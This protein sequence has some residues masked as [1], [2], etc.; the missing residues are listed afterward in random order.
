MLDVIARFGN[1]G[2]Q[3]LQQIGASGIF[4]FTMLFRKPGIPRL[5]PL[6]RHQL[7]FIGVLSCLII[8]VSGLFIGMVVGLQGY[9]TLQKFGAGSQLGQLLALSIAREL[10]PVISA[11]LFAGRAGSALTAEIGLMKTTEQLSSMD[12]MG[13]D[14]LGR[15]IYPRFIAG[16]ISL[17]VLALIFSAVAIYGGYFVGVHWLGVDAGS[18]WSNMQAAVNFRIDVLS[19]IIKSIVFAFVVTWIAVYQGFECVPTAEGISQAT[20]KTVVYSSLAV[21]GLDFLLTAMMIG[22]W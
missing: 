15:V 16:C 22:D 4:L 14:P 10:G 9:H 18:F 6:L 5:W 1:R 21:L 8:V 13:V 7:Y 3:V 17:P 19:G 2:A 11:L 12:M 20:T